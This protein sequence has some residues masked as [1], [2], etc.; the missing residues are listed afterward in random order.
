MS[1]GTLPR[2]VYKLWHYLNSK[3][4]SIKFLLA[5][6]NPGCIEG[7]G[8]GRDDPLAVWRAFKTITGQYGQILD[9]NNKYVGCSATK[10]D[11]G[12][13]LWCYLSKNPGQNRQEQDDIGLVHGS[14]GFLIIGGFSYR[15]DIFLKCGNGTFI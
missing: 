7:Q 3:V 1:L 9:K 8:W 15:L 12:V 5:Y 13:C 2:A 6:T 11:P 10:N 14:M 4:H